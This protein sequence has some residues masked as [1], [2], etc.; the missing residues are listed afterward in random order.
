VPQRALQVAENESRFR[1]VNER[2]RVAEGADADSPELFSFVCECGREDCSEP[3][4]LTGAEY[5]R[6]RVDGSTFALLP[7]HERPEWEE[8]IQRNARFVVVR[9]FGVAGAVADDLDPRA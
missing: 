4:E 9:K 1:A 7:G 6:A 2:L 8:V 5:S 3:I